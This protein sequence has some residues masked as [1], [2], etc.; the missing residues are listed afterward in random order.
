MSQGS[1][2]RYLIWQADPMLF[3]HSHA[4]LKAK[5]EEEQSKESQDTALIADLAAALQFIQED[6]GVNIADFQRLVSYGEITYDLL[7]ALFTPNTL[8]HHY[9]ELTEQS[10][11]LLVRTVEYSQRQD[12][13]FYLRMYCDIISCD[14]KSFGMARDSSLEIDAF[15][16]ARKIQDL[17]VF[18]LKYHTDASAIRDHA[19]RRG[20]KFAQMVGHTYHE[21]SGPAMKEVMKEAMNG[22]EVKRFKFSVRT[23]SSS[24]MIAY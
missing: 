8:V 9:H 22:F 5:F 10:Q 3:F 21:I 24:L 19:V 14:G 13:S 18:P 4:A 11:I 1:A 15:Q 23:P 7:W 16:G 6:H 12:K 17:D 20:K 2:H